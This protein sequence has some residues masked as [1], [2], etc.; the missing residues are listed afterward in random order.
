VIIVCCDFCIHWWFPKTNTPSHCPD[1]GKPTYTWAR[2]YDICMPPKDAPTVEQLYI[3]TTTELLTLT[4]LNKIKANTPV[5]H[6]IQ[7]SDIIKK[8][9]KE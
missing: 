5:T 9:E 7:S 2:F 6:C 3:N 8:E 4:E 1:C